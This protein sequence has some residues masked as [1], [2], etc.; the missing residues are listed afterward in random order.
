MIPI[1]PSKGKFALNTPWG[2]LALAT[3]P[4]ETKIREAPDRIRIDPEFPKP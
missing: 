2:S 4:T 3:K 1:Q